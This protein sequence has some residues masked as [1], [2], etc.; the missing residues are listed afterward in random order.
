MAEEPSCRNPYHKEY[1][2]TSVSGSPL[3][4]NVVQL[5]TFY[6]KEDECRVFCRI[7]HR[8]CSCSS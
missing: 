5:T 4:V 2:Q 7:L 6:K 3:K 1:I 8:L